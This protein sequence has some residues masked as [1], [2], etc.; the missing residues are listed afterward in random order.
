MAHQSIRSES[1]PPPFD[2]V[3]CNFVVKF[4][5]YDYE[6]KNQ[7]DLVERFTE[8]LSKVLGYWRL[9]INGKTK[10]FERQYIEA[11]VDFI[12]DVLTLVKIQTTQTPTVRFNPI[13]VLIESY[14]IKK[15]NP[16]Q[17]DFII[18]TIGPI[19]WEFLHLVSILIKDNEDLRT[20]FAWLMLN[21]NEFIFCS[22]CSHN[23]LAKDF[24]RVVFIPIVRGRDTVTAIYNLHNVVNQ[25]VNHAHFTMKQFEERFS[26]L[27][28]PLDELTIEHQEKLPESFCDPKLIRQVHRFTSV[29]PKYENP[30]RRQE[31]Y[32]HPMATSNKSV[33]TYSG[34]VRT[35]DVIRVS[36]APGPAFRTI[37]PNGP[38]NDTERS[39]ASSGN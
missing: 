23:Y 38:I 35:D 8:S 39:G 1:T 2:Y 25:S 11:W 4:Q 10:S 14:G 30:A 24:W 3:T 6:I 28:K 19:Y 7:H 15:F 37:E 13:D 22:I 17:S 34:E 12:A 32:Q 16:G 29:E 20:R 18:T 9:I 26:V 36:S 21:F 33:N 27:A 5:P 31:F